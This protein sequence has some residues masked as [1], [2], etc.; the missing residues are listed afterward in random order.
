MGGTRDNK[1]RFV[2]GESGFKGRKHE[3]FGHVRDLARIHTEDA[4]RVLAEIMNDVDAE[5][6]QRVKAAEALL[7]RAWGR[8]PEDMTFRV[9]EDSGELRIRW[10]SD[11]EGAS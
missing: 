6:V 8:P 11:G 5:A 9:A 2:K 10:L 1:G 7:N 4:I 3:G